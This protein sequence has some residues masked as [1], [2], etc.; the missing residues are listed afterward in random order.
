MSL[1]EDCEY[2]EN[3]FLQP[4]WIQEQEKLLNVD[5]IFNNEP[6]QSLYAKFI[7]INTNQYIDKIVCK[8]LPLVVNEDSSLLTKEVLI[9]N[10][11]SNKIKN[12]FSKFKLAD[13]FLCN[14]DIL[15]SSIQMFSKNEI[16]K[17]N[18][19][20]YL[21]KVD[22]LNDLIIYPSTFI[23]H[24]I[25]AIY[26]I[27]EEEEVENDDEFFIPKSILKKKISSSLN[28]ENKKHTKKVRILLKPL[29]SSQKASNNITRKK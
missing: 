9:Q 1:S 2:L 19:K 22:P 24:D 14:F 25:N 5:S 23:F 10:I 11:D 3:N 4:S 6:M 16:N 15:P 20:T 7:Y 17:H 21:K 28:E 12:K 26:F 18:S 8:T 29:K 13:V 27:F